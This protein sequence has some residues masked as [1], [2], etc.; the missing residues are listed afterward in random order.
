MSAATAR[1]PVPMARYTVG[2][3]AVF[4]SRAGR[5]GCRRGERQAV[6]PRAGRGRAPQR[7][8]RM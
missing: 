2:G 8:R 7:R 3:A 4:R 1:A 6:P 5:P